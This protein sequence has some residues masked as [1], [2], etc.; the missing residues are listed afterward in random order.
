MGSEIVS[1]WYRKF[2]E[3][4]EILKRFYEYILK[5]QDNIVDYLIFLS[6]T[7]KTQWSPWTYVD[8][9]FRT[10]IYRTLQWLHTT[11]KIDWDKFW[12]KFINELRQSR[13]RGWA[14]GRFLASEVYKQLSKEYVLLWSEV[15]SKAYSEKKALNE[16]I[17]KVLGMKDEPINLDPGAF[18][19]LKGLSYELKACYVLIDHRKPFL[20]FSIMQAPITPSHIRPGAS[21][22]DLYLFEE[23]LVVDIK[24]GQIDPKIKLP[25]YYKRKKKSGK[26]EKWSLSNDLKKIS[27]LHHL[28]G[29][30]KGIGV[31][32]DDGSYIHLAIYVPWRLSREQ[33]SLLYLKSVKLPLLVYVNKFT[34]QGVELHEAKIRGNKLT[35]VVDAYMV[36]DKVRVDDETISLKIMGKKGELEAK[37]QGASRNG[38]RLKIEF[39]V[40]S[41]LDKIL[42]I[43]DAMLAILNLE[44]KNLNE[45]LSYLILLRKI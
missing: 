13:K 26:E 28:Y 35:A 15:M 32:A 4:G 5:S 44:L 42:M 22:G 16:I 39:K 3:T 37:Y 7:E 38:R 10:P 14:I 24:G 20:P 40:E 6:D 23:N 45:T 34:G 12:D 30:R 31:V 2:S 8:Y 11:V 18:E 33:G 36:D 43:D 25:T 27:D 19:D 21:S 41:D 9:G 1:I 17:K 29:I